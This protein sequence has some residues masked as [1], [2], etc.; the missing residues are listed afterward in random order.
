MRLTTHAC[1]GALAALMAGGCGGESPRATAAPPS[2]TTGSTAPAGVGKVDRVDPALD[3]LVAPSAVIEKVAG[4]FMFT[5]GPLWRPDGT[6]WFSDVPGNVVRSLAPDGKITV[7]IEKAG[8]VAKRA[9]RCVHRVERPGRGAGRVGVDG[10]A[11]R[12]ADRARRS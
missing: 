6:L 3:A 7:L 12:Q 1:A 4:G 8:G 2:A 9:A 11:R 5:E 10:A